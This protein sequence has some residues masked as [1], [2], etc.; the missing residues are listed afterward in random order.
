M[1]PYLQNTSFTQATKVIKDTLEKVKHY[2]EKNTL[3]GKIS[4][5]I[6]NHLK[7][8]SLENKNFDEFR[9]RTAE[10]IILSGETNGCGETGLVFIALAREA[11]IPCKYVETLQEKNIKEKPTIVEGHIFTDIFVNGSWKQYDPLRGFVNKKGYWI[12]DEEYIKIGEG[13]DFSTLQL[14]SGEK[15][16]LNSIENVRNLRDTITLKY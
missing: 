8:R 4:F 12:G 15:I 6:S 3:Y 11:G 14:L 13:L 5:Y 10:D 1:E 2:Q 9:K 16:N 7:R